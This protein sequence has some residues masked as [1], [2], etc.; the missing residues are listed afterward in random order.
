MRGRNTF[1][2][3]DDGDLT[4]SDPLI[5]L[6]GV[7]YRGSLADINPADIGTIDVLKDASSQAIYGSQAANGVILITSKSGKTN[8]KPVINFS[9]FYSIETP[10]N[11]LTPAGR[12][13]F[14]E[15]YNKIFYEEAYLAPEY[16]QLI[17]T[18]DSSARFPY[19]SILDG[20][21]NGTNTDWLDVVSQSAHT[22]NTNISMAGNS[23]K[24]SYFLSAGY[25]ESKRLEIKRSI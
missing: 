6:D 18:F 13:G 7:I 4:G 22:Q 21:N 16:T 14:L 17:L 3:D 10:A 23:G 2:V 1:A 24:T 25:I 11:T 19:Q 9:S 15:H 20:F 12:D 5:V 8:Q